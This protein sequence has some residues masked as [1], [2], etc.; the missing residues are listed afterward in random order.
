M[1]KVEDFLTP[2]EEKAVIVAI[3]EAEQNTSGEIRV[4][5]EARSKMQP[6]DRAKELFHFLHMDNTKNVNGVLFYVAVE[7]RILVLL[8]DE[9]IDQVVPPDFW[10]STRETVLVHFKEGRIKQGLVDGILQA[11]NQLK[12][13]FPY[14]KGDINEL[15]NT[16]ST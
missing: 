14:G 13:H 9:G 6:V 10:E 15:P 5:L 4:H 8:G 11:G 7:D 2:D 1:S 12:Q 3:Q 16:I